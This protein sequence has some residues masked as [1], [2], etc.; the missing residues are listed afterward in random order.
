MNQEFQVTSV[1]KIPK[2]LVFCNNEYYSLLKLNYVIW[3][4][5][6][7]LWEFSM[8]IF[9]Y[10]FALKM[11]TVCTSETAVNSYHII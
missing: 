11:E 5:V 7:I 10:S 1:F 4:V 9:R 2:S 3:Q 6:V 8:Y